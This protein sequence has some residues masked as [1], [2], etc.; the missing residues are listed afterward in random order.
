MKISFHN[1]ELEDMALVRVSSRNMMSKY[2][3]S[4]IVAALFSVS[5]IVYHQLVRFNDR[6]IN[7]KITNSLAN[8]PLGKEIL[9]TNTKCDHLHEIALDMLS[10]GDRVALPYETNNTRW[11]F[12]KRADLNY[13]KTIFRRSIRDQ[14]IFIHLPE[15]NNIKAKDIKAMKYF[16]T[17][18]HNCCNKS[19]AKAIEA[20]RDPGGFV[21]VAA[22]DMSSLSEKFRYKHSAILK[23][24]RGAGYWLWKPYIILKTLVEK[25][26]DND[27]LMY[28]DA[29][30]YL[31]G[32][33]GPFL[34]LAQDLEP[35][36]VLFHSHYFEKTYC[37]RDSMILMDMDDRRV[38]ESYQR[39]ARYLMLRKD[40]QSLQFIMEWLAYAMD[41]RILTDIDNRMG[42]PNLPDFKDNRHDQ[43]VLSLLSKIWQLK[44]FKTPG[45]LIFHAA[46]KD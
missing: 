45:S 18:A 37:K 28:Q 2:R 33:A 3:W 40:C 21:F 24:K 11:T 27:L 13:L 26:S 1:K 16:I 6:K 29:D 39:S 4:L 20:A 36:I 19:K 46:G 14:P 9:T 15:Y 10:N 44:E 7:R 5:M 41:P 30:T 31:K 35:G 12:H 32:D 42:K 17:F 38:Y 22:H 34:K 23:Q 43:T 25:M 8:H